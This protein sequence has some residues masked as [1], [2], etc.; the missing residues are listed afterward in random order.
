MLI[1]GTADAALPLFAEKCSTNITVDSNTKGQVY[2]N[3]VVAKLINRPDGQVTAQ[4]AGTYIDITPR[5]AQPQYVT[6]AT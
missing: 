4:S 1:T 3:D 2:V 6:Y 5:G